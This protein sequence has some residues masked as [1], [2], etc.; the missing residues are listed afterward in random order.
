[1][2]REGA[3]IILD[4]GAGEDEIS[5]AD[6]VIAQA[7]QIEREGRRVRAI[8]VDEQRLRHAPGA[9]ES[10]AEILVWNGRIGV[11]AGLIS[12]SDLYI[13][14]DSAGQ[15]IAAALGVPCIDVFAGFSSSRMLERWRPFGEAETRVVVLD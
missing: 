12:Q 10:N 2:I 1:M 8:E 6:E 3:T 9:E 4:K 13:G 14:Y 15:H 11:L 7:T 5:R